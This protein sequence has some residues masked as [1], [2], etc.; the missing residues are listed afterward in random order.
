MKKTAFTMIFVSLFVMGPQAYALSDFNF[1]GQ[2]NLLAALK[3]LPSRDQGVVAFSVPSLRMDFEIPLK[4]SNE[5]F[6][7]LESTQFRDPQ[8]K[9]YDTQVK[10]AYLSLASLWIGSELRYGLVPNPWV[11]M[12][13]QSWEYD[14]WGP[15]SE[16]FLVRYNYSSWADL[17]VVFLSEFS[18]DWGEWILSAVNGEGGETEEIGKYKEVQAIISLQK[19]APFY[20]TIGYLQG[21]YDAFEDTFHDKKRVM[22]ELS[23]ASEFNFFSVTYYNTFDP[24]NIITN[25][26]MAGGVNVVS[27]HGT[28]VEGQAV[29]LLTRRKLTARTDL[30]LRADWLNPVKSQSGNTLQ[31]FAGGVGFQSSDDLLWVLAAEQTSFGAEFSSSAREQLQF[32]AATQVRF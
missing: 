8:S 2:F 5:I 11:E 23:F 7:E 16:V 26:N 27:L 15:S 28:N 13:R 6:V 14:F 17:G 18:Q 21:A 20:L 25:N 4:E 3:Q 29:S 22:A 30:F 9:R 31:A 19:Y 12:Q 10:E 32:L 1:S 24:A